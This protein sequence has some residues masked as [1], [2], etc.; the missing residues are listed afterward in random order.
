[1]SWAYMLGSLPTYQDHEHQDLIVP[2]GAVIWPDL[3]QAL[4]AYLGSRAAI[5]DP[6]TGRYTGSGVFLVRLPSSLVQC[7]EKASQAS[8][9][10]LRTE[11]QLIL[12]VC[13]DLNDA[14]RTFA[15]FYR[16]QR[17]SVTEVHLERFVELMQWVPTAKLEAYLNLD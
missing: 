11:A 6:D 15:K 9:W 17:H 16:T 14:G 1:M 8:W 10:T 4:Q 5:R 13:T 7:A 2:S 12:T 3:G